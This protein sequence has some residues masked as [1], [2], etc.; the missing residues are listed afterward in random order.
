MGQIARRRALWLHGA[1][2][3]AVLAA[4][5]WLA[6]HAAEVAPFLVMGIIAEGILLVSAARIL[7]VQRGPWAE[8]LHTPG[9]WTTLAVIRLVAVATAIAFL[10]VAFVMTIFGETPPTSSLALLGV[11]TL[12]SIAGAIAERELPHAPPTQAAPS[13]QDA[14][15]SVVYKTRRGAVKVMK[16]GQKR[17]YVLT[18]DSNVRGLT[19]IERAIDARGWTQTDVPTDDR[20]QAALERWGRF[21]TR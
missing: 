11:A 21:E 7:R 12:A 5:L 8:H 17:E 2:G 3:A 13:A 14:P 20:L 10:V 1:A 19:D 9:R 15:G 4:T 16:A 6:A 18:G